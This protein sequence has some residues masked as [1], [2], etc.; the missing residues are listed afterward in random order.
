MTR[1]PTLSGRRTDPYGRSAALDPEPALP[2]PE[3]HPANAVV[4]T[5]FRCPS[6]V[7]DVEVVRRRLQPIPRPPRAIAPSDRAHLVVDEHLTR[8]DGGW[9]PVRVG[10][11]VAHAIDLVSSWTARPLILSVG[12]KIRVK[13]PLIE[14]PPDSRFADWRSA[15]ARVGIRGHRGWIVNLTSPLGESFLT[16]SLDRNTAKDEL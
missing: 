3:R 7:A 9:E 2:P 8:R 13:F 6:A 1:N 10:G 11:L 4:I 14:L 5:Q 16:L 15:A 12:Q